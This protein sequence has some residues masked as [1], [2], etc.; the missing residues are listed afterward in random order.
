MRPFIVD[1]LNSGK[2]KILSSKDVIGVGPRTVAG[3]LESFG[4]K[5]RIALVEAILEGHLDF[6]EYDLM[7]ASGM[8]SD[9][10]AI[11]R[12]VSKWKSKSDLPV[13]IGGPI[14]SDPARALKKTR[15]ETGIGPL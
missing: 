2:G 11:R 3:I 4:L 7:L 8:T 14:A 1:A 6:R 15:A 9:I 10:T 12:V 5:P 13:L